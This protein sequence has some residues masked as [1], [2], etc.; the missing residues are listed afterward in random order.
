MR[1]I[2]ERQRQPNGCE[3]SEAWQIC[4]SGGVPCRCEA[5]LYCEFRLNPYRNFQECSS[6]ALRLALGLLWKEFRLEVLALDLDEDA[7]DA[8]GGVEDTD[9]CYGAAHRSASPAVNSGCPRD[10]AIRDEPWRSG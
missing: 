2:P 4:P 3:F 10:V 5:E 8:V 9:G 6:I 7:L 1:I